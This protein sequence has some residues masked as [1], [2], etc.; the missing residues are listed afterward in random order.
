MN[1]LHNLF[2]SVDDCKMYL[3]SF[4]NTSKLWFLIVYVQGICCI[5]IVFFK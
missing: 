2:C 1:P 4:V 3:Q 5:E